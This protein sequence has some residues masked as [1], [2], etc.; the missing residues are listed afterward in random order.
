MFEY[1][2]K[3]ATSKAFWISLG[4]LI[5]LTLQVFGDVSMLPGNYDE[6]ITT[7]LALLVAAGVVNDPTTEKSW[8]SDDE[9][10][11]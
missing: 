1:F 11:K 4:A 2:K 6:I 3:R 8:Y 7:F 5:P 10:K 9:N